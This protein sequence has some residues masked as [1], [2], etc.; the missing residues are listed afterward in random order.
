[1]RAGWD[2]PAEGGTMFEEWLT[3]AQHELGITV[4]L[5][6]QALLD[7]TREVAHG[8]D[9]PAAPLTTFL[10]GYLA[11]TRGGDQAASREAAE[12]I[13]NLARTWSGRNS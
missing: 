4:A 6:E 9:R 7:V 13:T 12:K 3:A 5:D 8:V 10:L 2:W 11:G 1:M